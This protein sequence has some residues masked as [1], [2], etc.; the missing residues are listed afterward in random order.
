MQGMCLRRRG[1]GNLTTLKFLEKAEGQFYVTEV[2]II[3]LSPEESTLWFDSQLN[4]IETD[5]DETVYTEDRSRVP[6][7]LVKPIPSKQTS[8][9][10][11]FA[12]L[13]RPNL[14]GLTRSSRR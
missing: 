5:E 8:P 13:K 3:A 1:R 10:Q 4:D 6:L 2:N 11:A 9:S 12:F 7:W 14:R